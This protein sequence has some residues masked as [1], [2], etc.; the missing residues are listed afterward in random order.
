M[1]GFAIEDGTVKCMCATSDDAELEGPISPM[2]GDT[3]SFVVGVFEEVA[4]LLNGNVKG[5]IALACFMRWPV[6]STAARHRSMR[7][8]RARAGAKAGFLIF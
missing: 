7:R 2:V 5:P 4:N 6:R 1:H 3:A 8:P